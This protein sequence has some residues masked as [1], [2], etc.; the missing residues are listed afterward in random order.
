[1]LQT[2]RATAGVALC[3]A[4]AGA[5]CAGSSGPPG[6]GVAGAP[7]V[8][9]GASDQP[10]P[11]G[12]AVTLAFAGDVHFELHLA[13]LLADPGA[14]LGPIDRVLAGADVTVVNLESAVTTRGSPARKGLEVP[15]ERYHFRTS[16][17]ALDLLAAA[18]VD[19]VSMANNHGAD[20]GLRGV[21]D[22]LRAESGSPVAVIG[23]GRNRREAFAPYR[24]TVRGTEIAVV[25]ADA[26]TREGASTLWGATDHEPGTA[27]AR[28][29]RP[30]VLLNQVR[31]LA[32]TADVVVV[33]LHWGREYDACPT[34]LQ[35][36]MARALTR[37]G[38]DV[39]VGSHAHRLLG[40]GW[41]P[42]GSY[43]NYGLGNFVWYHDRAPR[44]GVLRLRV[45][46]GR[47]V[48]DRWV[49]A[50]IRPDGTPERL[51]GAAARR[52]RAQHRASRTCAEVAAAPGQEAARFESSIRRI[53]PALRQRMRS[54]HGARCPLDHED[55]RHL[56]V[57]H[58]GFDG[59]VQ[60]GELVVAARQAKAV[61]DV[62]RT[63][64]RA[65]YPIRRMRLVSEYGGRDARS[66]AAN[67]TSA[68]NCRRVAGTRRWSD[69]AYGLAIDINP[70]QN[71]YLRD[72]A[73]VAPPAGRRFAGAG[74]SET[75]DPGWG[76][77]HA[78]DPVTRAFAAV[79][80]QWGGRW[81]EPDYQHFYAP[82][83]ARR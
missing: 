24:T 18:G 22:T 38:A 28:R 51:T 50:L 58:V 29:P 1:M 59:R 34:P 19:A 12:G 76:V 45:V 65:G 67:N 55:L 66:M 71:P 54:S 83:G 17:A 75:A 33:H 16:P 46:D 8:L 53:G 56:R 73:P 11:A 72:G 37:A 6:A 13:R 15:K 60:T 10:P 31:R 42:G 77:I 32:R 26:S 63:L 82:R 69:H 7:A 44:T 43:V 68:Y 81:A 64:F 41:L 30:R 47:V 70:V 3:A 48:Q 61:V 25:A 20:Y 14:G 79:G 35:R 27:A 39:I 62:F 2:R 36:T 57:S 80:W 49:P 9:T 40:S 5:A 52:A 23:I 4:L 78:G 21:R 74:R